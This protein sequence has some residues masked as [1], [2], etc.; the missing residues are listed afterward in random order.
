MEMGVEGSSGDM[1]N[2]E[3]GDAGLVWCWVGKGDGSMTDRGMT[4]RMLFECQI[5]ITFIRQT[6]IR[7][8]R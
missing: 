7:I 2:D 1:M 4:V 8:H 3:G 5:A 6:Y